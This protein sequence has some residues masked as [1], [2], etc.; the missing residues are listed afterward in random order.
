M[1]VRRLYEQQSIKSTVKQSSA[2]ARIPALEAQ[3][4]INSQPKEID[5]A[6]KE[7]KIPQNQHGG[8]TEGIQW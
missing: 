2:E 5:I 8:G 3:L 6:K 7:G 4:G 1:Q